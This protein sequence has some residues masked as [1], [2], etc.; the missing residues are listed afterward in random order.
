MPRFSR[1]KIGE[2]PSEAPVPAVTPPRET[3]QVCCRGLWTGY[4]PVGR[5]TKTADDAGAVLRGISF[6]LQRGEFVGLL[7]PNACGKTTLLRCLSGLLPPWRG[8]IRLQG[9][10]APGLR[11]RERARL[12]AHLPLKPESVP[13]LTVFHMVL[14][15]RALAQE[16]PL[17]FLDEATAGLDP[18]FQTSVLDALA[19]KNREQGLTVLAAM[20]DLNLAA[21]Y[22]RRLILLRQGRVLADGPTPEV[23]TAANLRAAYDCDPI[24]IRHPDNGLPQALP[25]SAL[26]RQ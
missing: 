11:D 4:A 20:H 18:A 8:S 2:A 26:S 19:R 15:A 6:S 9:R 16:S 14:L 7:G 22:C 21:L 25:R 10:P 17:L 13:A 3:A 24:L 1:L 5:A 12:L 23:F